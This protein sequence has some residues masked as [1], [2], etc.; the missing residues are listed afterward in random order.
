MKLDRRNFIK[1][2]VGGAVGL[3]VTPLPWK[4]TDDIAIWTQN[5][6]WV[7]V[8]AKGAFD[9]E[10]SVCSLCPGGCGIEVRKVDERAVKVEGRE[11]YPINP[12]GLCPLGMGSLQLLYNEDIRFTGPM[13]R[14]GPRGAGVFQ[15]ISW[16]EALEILSSR[17]NVLR[18]NNRPEAVAAIDGN[19]VE[20]T[21]SLLIQR[22]MQTIGSPNYL[23]VPSFEDTDRMVNLLM[24]GVDGPVA[25]DL[26][27][28]DFILSFGCGLLEGWGAPGR[29]LGLWG[30]WHDRENKHKPTV[31]QVESRASNTASKADQWVAA[32]PGTEAALAL[33]IA[34]VII[35][36][37][38]Y[39]R[40]FIEQKTFGFHPWNAADWKEHQG[41]QG[42]VLSEYTPRKVQEITG[43]PADRIVSLARSFAKA[44]APV[45]IWG[46]GKGD[47]N[48]SLYESMCVHSLNA[49][50]GNINKPGGVLVLDRLPLKQLPEAPLDPTAEAGLKKTPVGAAAAEDTP[51]AAN[52]L[53][54]FNEALSAG[55]PSPVE[56]L[57]VFGANPAFTMPDGGS[58]RRAL[59]AVP[60]IVS[61]SPFRDE[62]AFMADL[63]L[64][65]HMG[66][67]KWSE[68]IQPRGVQYPL[69][70]L[71]KPVVKPLYQ[72]QEAGETILKLARK[73]DKA[74]Q[75]A[76]P[77]KTF[78]DIMAYRAEGLFEAGAGL[79]R[80]KPA[81]PPWGWKPFAEPA[82]GFKSSKDMWQKIKA[83]GLWYQPLDHQRAAMTTFKTPSGQFEFYSTRL[84]MKLK[85][86]N[87]AP[88]SDL[89]CMPHFAPSSPPSDSSRYPLTMVP[90]DMVNL[91]SSWLPNPP[92][93]NKTL[94]PEQLRKDASYAEI[95]PDT[96]KAYGLKQDD[97]VRVESAAGEVRVRVCLFEG[98][99][100]GVVYLPFGLGHTAYDEFSRNKGV[101]PNDIITAGAD[102]L[103][104]LP[105]WWKTPVQLNKV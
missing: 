38:L 89:V 60:F 87:K 21:A 66:F 19:P 50:V 92:F 52:L 23:R 95:H 77:W 35:K 10:T 55:G 100:P 53:T 82:A 85:D 27:N 64:P 34:H 24:Q 76:F 11:D 86:L 20:S 46:K 68:I 104:G 93:L 41:F 56:L 58:M 1:L 80:Y 67:E 69:Y 16:D 22:L 102:P 101:N 7:P 30:K 6:P 96:A 37:G 45:A 2:M 13:K 15:D 65:D 29:I 48:G 36:D 14:V 105:V 33:G 54:R 25:Y 31:V 28:A 70:G 75:E 99:M 5:W 32:A 17:V 62:T 9:H 8:P 83:S 49:L 59:K 26:E 91:V 97:L 71:G 43:V 98:A 103:S 81:Q 72:T 44:K 3:Q 90:Y 63:V 61:F 39:D 74:V 12:G 84:E 73:L 18:R 42:L 79:V 94:F 47:L 4:I 88:S 51:F 57:M 78:E 40:E